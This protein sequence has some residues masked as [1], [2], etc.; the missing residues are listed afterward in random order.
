MFEPCG[1]L[2]RTLQR[3]MF[4]VSLRVGSIMGVI[5]RFN[6]VPYWCFR[7]DN[8]LEDVLYFP[9]WPIFIKQRGQL[10]LIHT[11]VCVVVVFMRITP[12]TPQECPTRLPC[13]STAQLTCWLLEIEMI[14]IFFTRSVCGMTW[15]P[16]VLIDLK[17]ELGQP[18]HA[19]DCFWCKHTDTHTTTD[20]DCKQECEWGLRNCS[21]ILWNFVDESH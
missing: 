6:P 3:S 14:S 18:V 17:Q 8:G 15:S 19:G 2:L 21:T 12:C 10:R 1:H 13:G 20:K 5:I 11:S 7:W 4:V 9:V 16:A